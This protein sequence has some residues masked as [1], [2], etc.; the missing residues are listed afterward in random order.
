MTEADDEALVREVTA[1]L[2][3]GEIELA[4]VVV[5]TDYGRDEEVA[6]YDATAAIGEIVAERA[7][8]S[9]WYVYSGN[10]EQAF[11]SNQHQGL[12]LADDGFVWECQH[13][14]RDGTFDIVVYYEADVDQDRLLADLE[15]EGF[16]VTGVASP[17]S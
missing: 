6:V 12:G 4:G 16:R 11:A 10:D 5:H 1:L 2:V 3:P 17:D 7:G 8:A 13:I 14:V 9:E 15:E